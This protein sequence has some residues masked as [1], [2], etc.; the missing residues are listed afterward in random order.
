MR[1]GSSFDRIKAHLDTWDGET[2][3]PE[4]RREDLEVLVRRC[5]SAQKLG[6]EL[7]PY[8]SSLLRV[9]TLPPVRL[10]MASAAAVAGV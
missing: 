4:S 2:P 7:S 5:E 9:S 3:V 6:V 1:K 10:T 8:M